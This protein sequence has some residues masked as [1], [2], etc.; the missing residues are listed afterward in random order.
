[1]IAGEHVG[2]YICGE[3]GY[4]ASNKTGFRLHKKATHGKDAKD[5]V[6][7]NVFSCKMCNEEFDSTFQLKAHGKHTGHVTYSV[8]R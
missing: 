6:L 8:H 2:L 5:L 7:S 1:M 4:T 3:C